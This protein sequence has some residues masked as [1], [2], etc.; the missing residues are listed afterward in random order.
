M[1]KETDKTNFAAKFKLEQKILAERMAVTKQIVGGISSVMK[2]LHQFGRE[3]EESNRHNLNTYFK[4]LQLK[5]EEIGDEAEICQFLISEK[6]KA[7]S[8]I[9]EAEINKNGYDKE[10]YQS[11]IHVILEP[12]Y[13]EWE[14]ALELK[15]KTGNPVKIKKD[16]NLLDLGKKEDVVQSSLSQKQI[17]SEDELQKQKLISDSVNPIPVGFKQ[18]TNQATQKQIRD[19]FMILSKEINRLNLK[20]YMEEDKIE[21]L[22]KKNFAVF[23]CQPNG[24]YFDINLTKKQKGVLRYFLYQFYQKYERNFIA[25]K[26]RYVNFLIHN[27][28]LFKNDNPVSLNSNM[29]ETKQPN[30]DSVI[31]VSKYLKS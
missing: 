20:P 12:L 1:N 10:Y 26:M 19:Y 14:K 18:I 25:T 21:E 6:R 31:Q 23:E 7:S 3:I 5:I 24:I 22:I 16:H 27:F 17:L 2:E 13:K 30:A 28:E 15:Q 8:K 29:S 11:F 4:N 9:I